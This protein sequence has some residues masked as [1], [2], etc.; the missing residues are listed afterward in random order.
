MR[1]GSGRHCDWCSAFSTA[2]RLPSA[3]TPAGGRPAAPSESPLTYPARQLPLM[4]SAVV[5]PDGGGGGGAGTGAGCGDASA[6][7]PP[8]RAST[9]SR[10]AAWR[11]AADSRYSW[12]RDGASGGREPVAVNSASAPSVASDGSGAGRM[13]T[14]SGGASASTPTS[15]RLHATADVV[16][17]THTLPGGGAPVGSVVNGSGVDGRV[18]GAD[19]AW[20][21][22]G[23]GGGDPPPA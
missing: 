20:L 5:S 8:R 15:L 3:A 18:G 4:Y 1:K 21:A 2:V 13:A 17:V 11:R 19:A 14:A 23:G 22:G 9:A 7:R 10:R 12:F 16:D 6:R